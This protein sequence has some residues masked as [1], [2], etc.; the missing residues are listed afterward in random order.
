M[1]I[2]TTRYHLTLVRMAIIK[3]SRNNKCWRGFEERGILLHCWWEYK[4]VQVLRK[5][6][7]FPKK[8][9]IELPYDPTIPLLHKYLEKTTLKRFMY[10]NV[11]YST[12]YK[13]QDTKTTRMSINRWTDKD[14]VHIYNGILLSHIKE[15]NKAICSNRH[16]PRD[17]TKW[18]KLEKDKYHI[19]LICG[20][21]KMIHVNFF[22]KPTHSHRKQTYGYQRANEEGGI[23]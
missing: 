5:T 1:Q 2:K 21:S 9:E 13:S 19:S 17:Q 23:H 4:L 6:Q 10:P 16:G 15:W 8:L 18:R 12:V 20:I 11:H 14:T 7:R 22:T 3:K